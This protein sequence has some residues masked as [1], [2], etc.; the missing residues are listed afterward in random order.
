MNKLHLILSLVIFVVYSGCSALDK[1]G[2]GLVKHYTIV[3]DSLPI[4]FDN[5]RLVFVS[6]FHYKSTLRE[7]GLGHIINQIMALNADLIILGGDYSASHKH[8]LRYGNQFAQ[9]L[10]KL[11][12]PLGIYAIMGNHDDF[13]GADETKQMLAKAQITL[14]ENDNVILNKNGSIINI[15]GVADK[16]FN[17]PNLVKAM[18]GI[19]PKN[20]SILLS[21]QGDFVENMG[22][23][24][25]NLVLSGH[26]H[27]GQVTYFNFAPRTSSRYGQK[28]RY[29]LIPLATG[30]SLI[31]TSG[32]GTS[33]I[34][35]RFGPAE[36]IVII[37][38]KRG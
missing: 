1:E 34:N 8:L 22:D 13:N 30:G 4:A 23:V 9:Y 16:R 14:L 24:A 18:Q 5:T 11:S 38:L 15:V 20:F 3:D 33:N 35:V 2:V 32:L 25:F 6:D 26:T 37:T 27:A 17:N 7:A 21:H 36:E 29:G 31:V 12:A 19:N 28:Y 10:A